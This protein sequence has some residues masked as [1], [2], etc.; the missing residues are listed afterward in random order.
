MCFGLTSTHSTAIALL[1]IP[2]IGGTLIQAQVS[3]PSSVPAETPPGGI[4][5]P[6][7]VSLG[8]IAGEQ[9]RERE[10]MR[11]LTEQKESFSEFTCTQETQS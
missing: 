10:E 8:R 1:T 11:H 7:S 5:S 2:E 9:E 6:S 4:Y 3:V